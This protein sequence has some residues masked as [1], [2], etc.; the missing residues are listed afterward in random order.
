M[1]NFVDIDDV[2]DLFG[3]S[4]DDIYAKHTIEDAL[5]EGTL[6]ALSLP[7]A[8]KEREKGEW[9]NVAFLTCECSE[10][11]AQFHELEYD[12]FCPNCGANMRG[13]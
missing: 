6:K 11:G 9:K 2:L 10:C 3:I 1:K 4:D 7:S 5:Y 13:E 8:E 12:N